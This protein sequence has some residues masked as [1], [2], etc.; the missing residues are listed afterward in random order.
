MLFWIKWLGF[1]VC[2]RNVVLKTVSYYIV[3]PFVTKLLSVK[4]Q[5]ALFCEVFIDNCKLLFG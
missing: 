2:G 3:H 5:T 4:E 1:E